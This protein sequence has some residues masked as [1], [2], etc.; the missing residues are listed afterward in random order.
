MI[1][2]LKNRSLLRRFGTRLQPIFLREDQNS[3]HSAW[4]GENLGA[5]RMDHS[6]DAHTRRI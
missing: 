6:D 5:P 1:Y 2:V 3:A 4:W